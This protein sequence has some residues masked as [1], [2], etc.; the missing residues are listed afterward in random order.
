MHTNTAAVC[1]ALVIMSCA[2]SSTGYDVKLVEAE[3]VCFP[4]AG[5]SS[6][7]QKQLCKRFCVAY[8]RSHD[9]PAALN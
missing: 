1:I 2:L 7:E 6:D 9:P 5:C 3:S 4:V 8:G